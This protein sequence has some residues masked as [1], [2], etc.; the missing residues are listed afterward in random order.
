MKLTFILLNVRYVILCNI[1]D[2]NRVKT[3]VCFNANYIYTMEKKVPLKKLLKFQCHKKSKKINLTLDC[4]KKKNITELKNRTRNCFNK[5][6]KSKL[7]EVIL[8]H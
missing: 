2:S 7:Y 5:Y 3:N 1:Y 8:Y 4:Y 6:T